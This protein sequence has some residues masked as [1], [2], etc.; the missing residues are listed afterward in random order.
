MLICL[1]C[2]G[3]LRVRLNPSNTPTASGRIA[4]LSNVSDATGNSPAPPGTLP[5]VVPLPNRFPNS[6]LPSFLLFP[7]IHPVHTTH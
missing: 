5:P 7:L 2:S 4:H 1:I 3:T 6:Q